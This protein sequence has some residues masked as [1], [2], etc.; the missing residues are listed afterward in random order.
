MD[1]GKTVTSKKNIA[2]AL[3]VL[4][5]VAVSDLLLWQNY[6]RSSTPDYVAQPCAAYGGTFD[7]FGP[8]TIQKIANRYSKAI[9]IAT[10]EDPEMARKSVAID[11][12]PPLIRVVKV[13]KGVSDIQVNDVLPV[14]PGM[15][16]IELPDGKHPTILVFLEG[17]DGD[18]WVPTF[19]YFGIAPKNKD[20]R[21]TLKG[22]SKGHKSVS[23]SE[24]R[25][26]IN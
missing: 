3:I 6:I 4:V 19:G 22:I 18:V 23:E 9:V 5:I 8:G 15:G 10:V 12:P 13:L 11:G 1:T 26:V 16:Y 17:K 7:S 14:C 25:K 20:G 2:V 21:F 24:L